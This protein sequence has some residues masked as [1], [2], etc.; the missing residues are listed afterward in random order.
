MEPKDKRMKQKCPAC[1]KVC[2]AGI[3]WGNHAAAHVKRGE[4]IFQVIKGRKVYSV[5]AVIA[6]VEGGLF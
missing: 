1:G 6:S 5:P 3:A 2:G 4:L